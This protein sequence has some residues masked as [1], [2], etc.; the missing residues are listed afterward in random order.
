VSPAD[1]AVRPMPLGP[2]HARRTLVLAHASAGIALGGVQALLPALPQIQRALALSD[3]QIGMINSAYLLP[4]VLFA[5]PAGF[6]ADRFGRRAVYCGALSLFGLA[7]LALFFVQSF[8]VLLVLRAVQGAAFAALLPLSITLVGDLL[9]GPA[10]VREQSWRM[11]VLT[12][13]DTL[14]ALLGGLLVL[15]AWNVPFLLHTAALP[16]ALIGWFLLDID[17]TIPPRRRR[18]FGL[19]ALAGLMR[20]PMAVS[21]QLLGVLRFLFKFAVLTYSPILLD[22]RGWSSSAIAGALAGFAAASVIAA[23]AT[24]RLL[25]AVAGSTAIV[26]MLVGIAAAFGVL[27]TVETAAV[28]LACLFA[29]G[30]SE[31]SFGIIVNAMTLEG[32]ADDQRAGFVAA[33]GAFRN[34]GKF[35]APTLLGLAV[36]RLPLETAFALVGA[37]ALVTITAVAPLRSLDRRLRGAGADA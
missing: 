19:R 7:G 31:G 20:T 28:T 36:L 1:A 4:S 12:A 29:L 26:A 25:R 10:Q 37:L 18:R 33:V 34:L 6:L 2:V 3:A 27:A 30:A 14:L 22:A 32:V 8:E 24:R 17:R 21:I 11:L 13:S 16:L 35:L 5:V 23:L 15:V 9:S